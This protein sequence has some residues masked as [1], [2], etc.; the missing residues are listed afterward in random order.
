MKMIVLCY[1]VVCLLA[2]RAFAA[3]QVDYARQIKPIL[4][5]RCY[6]C[7]GA[8]KQESELRL[9]TGTLIRKGGE[10]G[11]A[12][13]PKCAEDSLLVHRIA[14]K[15][16]DDRMPPEGEPITDDQIALIK[17]WIDQG[18]ASPLDERGDKDPR[19][20]WALQPVVRP[21]VPEMG[22]DWVW[23]P[24]D[25]FI[26]AKLKRRRL[27]PAPAARPLALLRRAYFDLIGL[28]PSID[29][30]RAVA[31]AGELDSGFFP[32][33][34]DRLLAS[35]HYG[36]RWGRHWLDV[37]RYADTGG[38]E[39]DLPFEGAWKYRDYVIRSFNRD[40]PLDRF[41]QEQV[42]GDELWPDDEDAVLATA[43]YTVGPVI[44]DSPLVPDKLEYEF[45]TDAVDT[46]G[47]VF[48]GLTIGCSR[49]HDHMYDP[50]SQRDYFG[51]QA[52]F[53]ASDRVYPEKMLEHREQLLK[54][55]AE[56]I[57][58]PGFLG[59]RAIASEKEHGPRLIRRDEPL[60]VR[61]LHR[62]ELK[63]PG[64][65][66]GPGL[67]AAL[68]PKQL[69][70]D[71]RE[72]FSAAPA[73][74]RRAVLAKWLT[75]PRN[76]LTARVIVNRVWA[77]HFGEGL[78]RTP[79]DFGNQGEPPSHPEL[80][81][82]LASELV[83]SGWSLKHLHRLIMTSS[84]YRMSSSW[85]RASSLR[86]RQAGSLSPR[87]IDSENRLLWRFPR[88]RLEAE[89]IRDQ[90]F[91][92]AGTLNR[93]QFGP[94]VYPRLNDEEITGLF[95]ADKNWHTTEDPAQHARRSVYLVVK[96][97]F[98]V[99]WMAIFDPSALMISC[100]K[101]LT[102]NV[103]AQALALLNSPLAVEQA[104]AF[105]GRLTRECGD[106]PRA[107]I[108]TAW[109]LAFGRPITSDEAARMM[110]F[111]RERE[112]KLAAHGEISDSL[113][114]TGAPHWFQ[115]NRARSVALVDLCLALFNAN[116]FVYAD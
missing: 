12:I 18:A 7:H 58:P 59:G 105:A 24:I 97:S 62:G 72:E 43:L 15:D 45:L 114:P 34:V 14:S 9:D 107:W 99:P 79:N 83:S 27:R 90:M 42:A 55:Q 87:E 112:N 101:R 39:S 1:L 54:E 8:F 47:A 77:W 94:P 93:S 56:G 21:Q 53:A 32:R 104:R 66:I 51:L 92:C 102:T 26:L 25:A 116:E 61:L 91:A 22:G 10:S 44:E 103:P 28:T 30:I 100:P 78:V 89:I 64:K 6:S 73:N 16:D 71:V 113:L 96:R 67:P 76:P 46:T 33:L 13:V 29:D 95:L 68:M 38:F 5:S 81:D 35:P 108:A 74:R 86:N 11:P 40:K 36:E 65:A 23:N 82:W 88:R 109:L 75:S 3:E 110:E 49:C 85:P 19:H 111:L 48:L 84:T 60:G 115:N 52:V 41:I 69:A 31:T 98:R 2:A 57:E 20:Y 80:L 17:L 106:D 37:A 50:I 4:A 70:A 63:V